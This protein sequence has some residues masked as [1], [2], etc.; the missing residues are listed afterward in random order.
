ML[1]E[2]IQV[3]RRLRLGA[4]IVKMVVTGRPF[5]NEA[6]LTVVDAG[7]LQNEHRVGNGH[8]LWRRTNGDQL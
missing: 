7:E 6:V 1:M 3:G 4:V 8:N 5:Q 2:K